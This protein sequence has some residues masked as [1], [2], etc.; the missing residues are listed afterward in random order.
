M[1]ILH[2]DFDDLENRFGGGQAK[3]TFE[4]NRRLGRRHQITVVTSRYPGWRDEVKEGIRYVRVGT[5]RSPWDL[6]AWFA[7]IPW[8]IRRHEFD[9]LVED[10]TVPISTAF[11]P[12]FTRKPI[13][14]SVQNLFA[15][16]LSKKYTLP[17]GAAERMGCRLYR[18]FI[19]PTQAL[20]TQV[21]RY[22]PTAKIAVIPY[23]VDQEFFEVAPSEEDYILFLGRIDIY[24]KGLDLLLR[25]FRRIDLD[26]GT[27]LV[28]AGD[29]RDV[30]ALERMV[31]EMA[32]SD[33]VVYLGKVQGMKKRELLSK[34]KLVCLPSRYEAM[35]IVS[36]ES[37]ASRK[38]IVAFDIPALRDVAIPTCAIRV[39]CFSEEAY[40]EGVLALLRDH[41]RRREMGAAARE[42]A[43]QFDWDRTALQQESFY[44]EALGSRMG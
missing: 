19:V 6:V 44:Q 13:V 38:P 28:I 37:F 32:L 40:A 25:A 39:P 8:V 9:L 41:S 4:V 16:P 30:A 12:A 3:R 24:Q 33:R 18:N 22:N 27:R 43:R 42:W 5:G 17:F 2:L 1:R 21:R 20:H 23:G 11:T 31:H 26:S 14:A 7:S 10:F 36:L 29:G 35:P 15:V 34:C